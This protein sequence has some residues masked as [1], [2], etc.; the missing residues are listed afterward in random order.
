MR[1]PRGRAIGNYRVSPATRQDTGRST[2]AET[3][4][5][6]H[7]MSRL[8]ASRTRATPVSTGL[9]TGCPESFT[10][11]VH[12]QQRPRPTGPDRLWS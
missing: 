6:L 1:W 2:E 9:F 11:R 4:H 5:T 12:L 10:E 8:V 3:E 7:P